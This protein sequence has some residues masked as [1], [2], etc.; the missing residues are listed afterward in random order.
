MALLLEASQQIIPDQTAQGFLCSRDRHA[1]SVVTCPMALC[2]CA[3]KAQVGQEGIGKTH[4]MQ[5]YNCS[6]IRAVL[7]LAK[8]QQLFG[9]LHEWLNRPALLVYSDQACRGEVQGISHQPEDL[10]GGPFP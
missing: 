8:P 3:L 6:P 1:S 4:Q 10:A 5:V 7:V 9:I 2:T